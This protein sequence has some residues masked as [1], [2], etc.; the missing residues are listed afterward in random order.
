MYFR[1]VCQSAGLNVASFEHSLAGPNGEPLATD[2]VLIGRAD[3]RRLMVLVSGTHGVETLCGSGCQSGFVAEGD[4]Q[5]FDEDLAVLL[6]HG[7]NCWG[8]AHLRRNNEDNVD[9][10]RNFVDFSAP[11][12][13]NEAYE[14]VHAALT[15]SQYRGAE[16]DR[17]NGVLADYLTRHG[18]DQYIAAIMG[19]QYRHAGGMA[20][21]GSKPTWSN[22]L[23]MSLLEP[24]AHTA[25]KVSV[26]E[27]HSGLGPY[28]YGTAVTMQTGEELG[29]VRASYGGWVQ[30]PNE[31]GRH[32][33]RQYFKA[34]GHTTEGFRKALPEAELSAVV[35]EYGTYP[36]AT[37]LPVLIDD[38][39]LTHF[40]DPMSEEGRH[41]K[42]RLVEMHYP[43]DPDWRQAVWDRSV[44]VVRQTYRI[45]D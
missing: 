4:W 30:A 43:D 36:P 13:E 42:G 40:G 29:R 34:Q 44:Q 12:P 37:S 6:I 22:S 11:L 9:L 32:G 38:H 33:D 21:G 24:F 20:Y 7:L 5:S 39:W 25:E 15:C 26:V 16:R 17:A 23:L 18:I 19:G 3:A 27:Y 10:N 45:L 8:A 2:S 35:L 28:G 14:A 31:R 41:I 1:D